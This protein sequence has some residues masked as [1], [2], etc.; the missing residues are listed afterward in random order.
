MNITIKLVAG[1]LPE[2]YCYPGDPQLFV[3]AIAKAITGV[4]P[5]GL[6][7][8]IISQTAPDPEDQDKGWIKLNPDL[9]PD[10]LYTFYNGLWVWRHPEQASSAKRIIFEGDAT[11]V[12][13]LDLP[14]ANF[15]PVTE[16]T[17]PFWE[18]DSNYGGRFVIGAGTLPTSGSVLSI[19]DT[20]GEETVSLT[21]SQNGPHVHTFGVEGIS[22]LPTDGELGFIG[23]DSGVKVY[24]RTTTAAAY[25]GETRS[26]G[27]GDPHNNMPQYRAANFIKRTARVFYVG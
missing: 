17:G 18:I 1:Q 5:S 4:A 3:N 26:K 10:L 22:G 7:G 11:D 25:L 15:D 24:Y 13:A 9:S 14:A 2:G 21:E 12:A 19:G 6:Q 16:T 20:G 8:L 27:E 23:G